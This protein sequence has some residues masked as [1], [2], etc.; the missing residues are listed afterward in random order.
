MSAPRIMYY[1]QYLLGIGHV[2]RS[3]LIVQE[4]CEQG[5]H[6]DVIFGGMPVPSMSFGDATMHQ[7]TAVKSVDA[8]FSSLVKAD[9][10]PFSDEDKQQRKQALL[11]LCD[12]LQP[13]LIVTE[14]Y[15]FGRRQMRFELLPLL[16]WVKSQRNPPILIASIR[17]ILQR[18]AV[19][20]EQE[21][22]E[23]VQANYQ[24]VLVHG[25]EDFYPLEKSFPLTDVIAD[26]INYSGYVCPQLAADIDE[27][28]RDTIVVSI[29]GGSVG[30]EILST[31]IALFNTGFAADKQWLLVTGPN[32]KSAD[33]AYFKALQQEKLQV[34][35]LADDFL[36]ALKNAYVS[37]S[38]AGYNTVMDLLLTKVPAV[39]VP[40]E[41]EGETEQLA[42][43]EV[44]TQGKV[45]QLV[46]Y[47]DLSVE[48][49]KYA[50]ENALSRA[51]ETININNQG[52]TQSAK[53][54]IEWATQRNDKIEQGIA[55]V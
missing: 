18:R 9:N 55:D 27:N 8:G 50:I 7:L 29:G 10:S 34:V 38:M 26:K 2:R 1:V 14:T 54:L 52:A 3:S 51:A 23:L 35:E 49:L 42:R 46:K 40:F 43:S 12:S 17:D 53:L 48:T 37:I 41:G 20:R 44:L 36:K 47:H 13:D 33:K 19:K 4:L 24:H 45:L 6:V 5:A 32:M 39:V 30:K 28:T 22:V 15:P 25:D 16:D 11:A 31:A 21:C